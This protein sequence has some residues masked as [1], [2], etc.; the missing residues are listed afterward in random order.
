[1]PPRKLTAISVRSGLDGFKSVFSWFIS[2]L[3]KRHMSNSDILDGVNK[4]TKIGV[5]S[6]RTQFDECQYFRDLVN[7]DPRVGG[8][9]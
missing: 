4:G 6:T 1:M 5:I 9:G 3:D 2:D 8:C 7:P